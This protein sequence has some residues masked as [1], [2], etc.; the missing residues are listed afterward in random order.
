MI[1]EAT[2]EDLD[3]LA[4]DFADEPIYEG[5]RREKLDQW[6]GLLHAAY[7]GEAEGP[8]HAESAARWT[9]ARQEYPSRGDLPPVS[10]VLVTG[11]F[12][13]G[14]QRPQVFVD[15]GA[16]L[17]NIRVI[18]KYLTGAERQLMAGPG[19]GALQ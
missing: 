3:Q 13:S 5:H 17:R 12:L 19:A 1:R 6:E 7:R 16:K 11:N 9:I 10:D 18:D 15:A 2:H 4:D 14:E 8:V